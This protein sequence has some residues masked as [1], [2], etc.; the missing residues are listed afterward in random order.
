MSQNDKK[1]TRRPPGPRSVRAL[2][3]EALEARWVL[4]ASAPTAD[5]ALT[6]GDS[7]ELATVHK[8]IVAGDP[9]G[10]PSDSPT[11]R[12]DPNVP[13]SAFGGV[14]SLYMDAP[15]PGG[16]ICTGTLISPS[17]V[18]TAGHCLDVD[19]NG[20]PDFAP[21]VV[22]FN[23]NYDGAYSSSHVAS[24]LYTHPNFTGFAN[25]SVLDDL[26]IV[27]LSSPAPAGVPYYAI[28]TA[29]FVGIETVTLVG[30]GTTG[31]AVNGY[32]GGSAGFTVK[33]GGRN[34]ADVFLSDDEGTGARE[35]FEWDFDGGHKKTNVFGSPQSFKLTLGNDI[36]TTIGGGDSG[37]PSFIDDGGG[38]LL[39]GVNTFTGGGGKAAAPYFGSIGGGIVVSSYAAWID[40]I[41]STSEVNQPPTARAGSD[42]SVLTGNQV[43]LDGSLSSDPEG[44]SL[45]YHWTLDVPT[46]S[47]ATLSDPNAV[48]TTFVADV[49]GSYTATLVVNDGPSDSAPDS[50]M[51]TSTQAGTSMHVG[52]IDGASQ[53][54][55]KSNKWS[56]DVTVTIHDDNQSPVAGATVTGQWSG[57]A[58]GSATGVTATNGTVNFS[59][60]NLSG[61]S[62]V[63]FMVTDVVGTLDYDSG[64]NHD[65]DGGDSDGTT[66]TVQKQS[67]GRTATWVTA[68]TGST[69]RSVVGAMVTWV[70]EQVRSNPRDP[71]ADGDDT[72]EPVTAWAFTATSSVGIT[73]ESPRS[74][75]GT[76]RG[77]GDESEVTEELLEALLSDLRTDPF[78]L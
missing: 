70:D 9:N 39:F 45:T 69:T 40:S 34:H 21:G 51:I 65:P 31:D 50:V 3:V 1:R 30:Y 77:I 11:A 26:A 10:S 5:V 54:K 12:V 22:T 61:G 71:M 56:A 28:N 35:G 78:G 7:L 18:L 38:L 46:G 15:G 25:P 14:G 76:E 42:Q 52:D 49:D 62:S 2:R 57:A 74:D 24:A 17:H 41:I 67:P 32:L 36:E 64:A 72:A 59:T 63:T 48:I 58:G 75:G 6:E 44:D 16:Y 53:V 19:D 60:G 43:V 13:T 73:R 33:R 29:P 68:P 37:G 20:S 47:A 8:M 4:N 55:G 27:E 23:L 66:I